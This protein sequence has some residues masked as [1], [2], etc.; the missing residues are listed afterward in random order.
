[1]PKLPEIDKMAPVSSTSSTIKVF[2]SYSHKDEAIK[3][4][5]CVHLANLRRQGKI[6]TWSDRAIEAGAEW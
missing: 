3:N 6:E 4:E 5:L 1:M 2:I